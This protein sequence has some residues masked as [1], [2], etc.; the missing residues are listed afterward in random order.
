MGNTN[1]KPLSQL[2]EKSEKICEWVELGILSYKICDRNFDCENCPLDKA[3]RGFLDESNIGNRNTFNY[4]SSLDHLVKIKQSD[5]YFVCPK[6][7]WV[8]IINPVEVKIGVDDVTAV[9]LGTI[10]RIEFPVINEKIF[11]D[12]RCGEVFR[13][14]H[15]FTISSPVNGRVTSVNI[16]LEERPNQ[17]T[18]DPLN[19]GWMIT[20]EPDNLK[21][22][23]AC[24]RNGDALFSWYLKEMKWVEHKLNESNKD[25]N[26]N[27]NK[28]VIEDGVLSREYIKDLPDDY[29]ENLVMSIVGKIESKI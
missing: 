18:L 13:G 11:K 10:D 20:V 24:C 9:V 12:A 21:Q 26:P 6:H 16:E 15:K 25:I 4:F 22:D 8:E 3:L 27:S 17:L 28:P 1:I 2:I 29:Y 23:L 5:S 7:T 14:E 19:K